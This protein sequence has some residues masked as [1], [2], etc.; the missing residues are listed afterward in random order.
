MF[1]LIN[2]LILWMD[3][4]Q[5]QSQ[6]SFIPINL[7]GVITLCI[8]SN[9]HLLYIFHNSNCFNNLTIYYNLCALVGQ[10]KNFILS[11]HGATMKSVDQ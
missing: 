7:K 10:I 9:T 6:S 11:V 1:L 8:D 5:R 4:Q 3:R 2:N